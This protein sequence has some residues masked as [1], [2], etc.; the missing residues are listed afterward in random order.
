MHH[1]FSTIG[2]MG[3]YALLI[4]LMSAVFYIPDSHAGRA[5]EWKDGGWL[6]ECRASWFST[7]C[8]GLKNIS[9][10]TIRVRINGD[11]KSN[12]KR[13]FSKGRHRKAD[14]TGLIA[15]HTCQ[16]KNSKGKWEQVHCYDVFDRSTDKK[17]GGGCG[18]SFFNCLPGW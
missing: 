5:C 12:V 18:C 17:S 11:G 7:G 2:M 10:E 8:I 9:G 13:K 14:F 1:K 4:Y 3:V 15:I 16:K 6:L